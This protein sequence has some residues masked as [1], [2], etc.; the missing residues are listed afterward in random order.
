MLLNKLF[1]LVGLASSVSLTCPVMAVPSV[2]IL[3]NATG[4]KSYGVARDGTAKK[5]NMQSVGS[6]KR[7]SSVH[8]P[9][10]VAKSASNVSSVA[11]V[12][13]IAP[14]GGN[15]VRLSG[16]RG[17]VIK[18]VGSKLSSNYTSHH[19]NSSGDT[20]DLEQRIA[21]LETRVASKQ[22]ALEFGDGINVDE[23]NTIGLSQELVGLPEIVEEL[24]QQIDG[25]SQQIDEATL[26]E[27]YYTADYI[28]QNYYDKEYI[29]HGLAG[30]NFM[31]YFDGDV[32]SNASYVFKTDA[33]GNGAWQKLNVQNSWDPEF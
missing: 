29:D 11:K 5:T 27:N 10:S 24:N 17:N 15:N 13:N 3:G 25:L 6:S 9:V 19:E 28:Q 23:H 14:Q 4:G 32:S 16:L 8:V 18:G 1:F 20:S 30:A 22:D 21:H 7:V 2:R 31:N 12:T 26:P 33:D